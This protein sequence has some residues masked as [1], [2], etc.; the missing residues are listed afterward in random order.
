[1]RRIDIGSIQL[2]YHDPKVWACFDD[3]TPDFSLDDLAVILHT[4]LA[5]SKLARR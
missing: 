5:V 4:P 1:V 2:R 3:L